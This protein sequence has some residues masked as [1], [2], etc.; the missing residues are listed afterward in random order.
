MSQFIEQL[1]ETG[2][3]DRKMGC[4]GEEC[5]SPLEIRCVLIL[6]RNYL[7]YHCKC[8]TYKRHAVEEGKADG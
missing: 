8:L 5:P 4:G 2:Y 3:V 7:C 6:E 1:C